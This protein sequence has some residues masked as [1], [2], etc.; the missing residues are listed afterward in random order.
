MTPDV[1]FSTGDVFWPCDILKSRLFVSRSLVC[2]SKSC[3]TMA[4]ATLDMAI[5]P[6]AAAVLALVNPYSG[7]LLASRDPTS[8]LC[9]R[10]SYDKVA[11]PATHCLDPDG[12]DPKPC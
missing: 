2:L 11:S 4:W 12:V 8:A 7:S 6:A 3:A 1:K 9:A 5:G 10:V